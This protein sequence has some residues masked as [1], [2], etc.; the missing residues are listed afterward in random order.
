ME[1]LFLFN[2]QLSGSLP[3]WIGTLNFLFYVD[4]S[5][6]SLEGE[7][8]AALMEMPMLKSDEITSNLDPR[9]LGLPV[10]N[11]PSPRYYTLGAFPAVMNLGN[12]YL[13]GEIPPETGQLKALHTHFWPQQFIWRD[14]TNDM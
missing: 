8:P 12:N 11:G 1:M 3:V 9:D 4:L 14:P 10:Y 13:T 5:N 7:I 2:N 6:N